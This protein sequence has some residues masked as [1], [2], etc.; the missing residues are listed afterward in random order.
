[1]VKKVLRTLVDIKMMI[2]L[3]H[4]VLCIQ[5]LVAILNVLMK[6]LKINNC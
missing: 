2:K 4:C 3:N 6:P 1:M 5:K